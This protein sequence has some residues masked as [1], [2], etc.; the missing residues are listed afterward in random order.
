MKLIKR[1]SENF[2]ERAAPVDMLILHYTGMKTGDEALA[3]MC[4][5]VSK[6]AAHFCVEEDGR[7]FWLVGED[8]RAWH[9]G[10][11]CWKGETDTNSR[12]IG[13]EIVNPGHEFGYRAF[14]KEQIGSVIRLCREILAD[15]D[16]PAAHV[17]GHS[18]VA[19]G[20]KE[21][22]G[23]LFPW[24]VLA[25]KDIGLFPSV[26]VEPARLEESDAFSSA[27][28]KFGYDVDNNDLTKVIIAFQR[29]FMPDC[30]GTE[31]EGV[32]DARGL[33]ILAELNRS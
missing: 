6:V 18:D 13:V 22:P 26:D 1:I 3:R 30:I 24:A 2:D 7:T 4:D 28:D 25:K 8:K 5:P 32:A 19:P 20:R 33:A 21:D 10:A 14:P 27:L 31:R 23:E 12:S 16:I 17:L 9:A 29:H 11:S 15:H